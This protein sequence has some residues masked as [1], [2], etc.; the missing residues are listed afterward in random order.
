MNTH[1]HTDL[2]H[3]P[4]REELLHAL[5]HF[6]GIILGLFVLVR[7]VTDPVMLSN[8]E[9]FFSGFC[10]SL[11]LLMVYTS[12]T[13][14]HL[15]TNH[16]FK[17]K[18]KKLDHASIYVLIAGTYTPFI[19]ALMQSEKNSSGMIYLAVV[20]TL[21]VMGIVFKMMAK[22]R[23]LYL[24]VMSYVA[25]GWIAVLIRK[26]LSLH[27]SQDLILW[28]FLGGFFYTAGVAFYLMKR[29]SYHHVIWHLFSCHEFWMVC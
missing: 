17:L 20:W 29:M 1:Q 12:S 10:F 8:A 26:E 28:I 24:S 25:M 19:I 3:Y 22:K 18:M 5:T 13:V 23:H 11:G 14:Y 4:R 15:A 27:F 21:A 2:L 7:S 16:Q 6:F 9:N